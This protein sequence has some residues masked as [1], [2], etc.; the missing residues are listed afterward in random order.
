MPARHLPSTC[1]LARLVRHLIGAVGAARA[2]LSDDAFIDD[3]LAG[4]PGIHL[5]MAIGGADM[6]VVVSLLNSYSGW[7]GGGRLHAENDLLIITGRARRAPGAIISYIMC[8]AMN[9]SILNVV[10]GGFGARG[11]ARPKLQGDKDGNRRSSPL[12]AAETAERCA[13]PRAWSSCPGYGMAVA[14]AQYLLVTRSRKILRARRQRPLCH[15]SRRRPFA[16]PHERAAPPKPVPYDIVSKW[17]RSMTTSPRPDV[18]LVIGAND[19]VNPWRARRT[20]HQS[21]LRHAGARGG[22]RRAASS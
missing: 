11:A 17:T 22:R 7:A 6:P 15:S 9:R 4:V 10:F 19:I 21:D 16:R 3:G 13:T 8:R 2:L 20:T 12:T 1:G 5:M 18:V 14:Q